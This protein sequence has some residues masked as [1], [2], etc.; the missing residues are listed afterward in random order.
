MDTLPPLKELKFLETHTEA[1][2]V[3]MES[4]NLIEESV[5]MKKPVLTSKIVS[6]EEL[7][8]GDIALKLERTPTTEKSK[9]PSPM[10]GHAT[11]EISSPEKLGY[12]PTRFK[13]NETHTPSSFYPSLRINDLNSAPM[14]AL[15]PT[16]EPRILAEVA[17]APMETVPSPDI[18]LL[19]ESL[20]EHSGSQHAPMSTSMS[21]ENQTSVVESILVS[22]LVP[23]IMDGIQ[24]SEASP[25][26]PTLGGSC[27]SPEEACISLGSTPGD[28]VQPLP[29]VPFSLSKVTEQTTSAI[30]HST[31]L[32]ASTFASGDIWAAFLADLH[33]FASQ[34]N[35]GVAEV[36]RT[37]EGEGSHVAWISM[38]TEDDAMLTRGYYMG[39]TFQG[40]VLDVQYVNRLVYDSVVR[41]AVQ[42]WRYSELSLASTMLPGSSNKRGRSLTPRLSPAPQWS[43]SPSPDLERTFLDKHT[44]TSRDANP[45]PRKRLRGSNQYPLSPSDSSIRGQSSRTRD[46]FHN[47]SLQSRR[48]PSSARGRGVKSRNYH[49]SPSPPH[50]YRSPSPSRGQEFR[51]KD[52]RR[53]PS[54]SRHHSSPPHRQEFRSREY[55]HTHAPRYSHRSFS[56]TSGQE[57]YH[58]HPSPPR[59]HRLPSPTLPQGFGSM[60]YHRRSHPQHYRSPP[61]THPRVSQPTHPTYHLMQ[62]AAYNPPFHHGP[63]T[64]A[65]DTNVV[66]A[67]G[68]FV[69]HLASTS[70]PGAFNHQSI[71]RV[72][73]LPISGPSQGP[74]LGQ[75][76]AEP[77]MFERLGVSLSDRIQKVLPLAKNRGRRKRGKRGGVRRTSEMDDDQYL[78]QDGSFNYNNCDILL[79][80]DDGEGGYH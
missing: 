47:P 75:L 14:D 46:G 13:K 5:L 9:E 4:N 27:L 77:P 41:I 69:T 39:A 55:H 49:F 61:P 73:A 31:Y 57:D 22:R 58:Y 71:P 6:S 42:Y 36:L 40:S 67:F 62:P 3:S 1:H 33:H 17:D 56:P 48:S 23:D 64:G 68:P 38:T 34:R 50:Y 54:P 19:N 43:R 7:S 59:H 72:S 11:R 65:P 52:Y 66:L 60:D 51:L 45:P 74:Y 10:E 12:V 18:V 24:N 21:A 25:I 78:D 76:D 15:V 70:Y 16:K 44:N 20:V 32:R 63:P 28:G 2:S 26:A 30:N 37:L 8:I 80:D 53:T 35:I 79:D 29:S